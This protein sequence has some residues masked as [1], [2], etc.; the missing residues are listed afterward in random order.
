MK[1]AT[2]F[3]EIEPVESSE[4]VLT[5]LVRDGAQEMLAA[6]LEQEVGTTLP[7]MPTRVTRAAIA[8]SCATDT[9]ARAR[10]RRG[11]A[12]SRFASRA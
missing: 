7:S 12:A 1:K 9:A 2:P 11:L 4:D 3:T 10:S 6:A 5:A 8:S